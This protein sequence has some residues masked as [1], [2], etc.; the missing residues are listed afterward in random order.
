MP[1][2]T[3]RVALP[4]SAISI[5]ASSLVPDPVEQQFP[6]T[7]HVL[8]GTGREGLELRRQTLFRPG[9]RFGDRF[10]VLQS[11][12]RDL[13]LAGEEHIAVEPDPGAFLDAGEDVGAY[14]VQQR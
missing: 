6:L 2:V 7:L 9:H 4:A 13:Q 10:G 1:T 11:A 5:A 3:I 8:L 14:P 12:V